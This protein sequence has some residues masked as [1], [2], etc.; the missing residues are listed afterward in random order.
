MESKLLTILFLLIFLF[1]GLVTPISAHMMGQPPSFKVN[2]V[3]T[4]N[5][6]IPA[7]SI[8]DLVLPQDIAPQN[9]LVD[10]PLNFEIDTTKLP[11]PLNIVQKL[12]FSWA[13]GD[14]ATGQGIANTHAYQK[15]GSYILT[16]NAQEPDDPTNYLIQSILINIVP[17]QNYQI[18]Q[19]VI[20]VLGKVVTNP[21]Q[22]INS[23]FSNSV[24]FD[25]SGSKSSSQ[26][27]SFKWDF[28]DGTE[29]TQPSVS[30]QYSTSKY[31]V[32]PVLRIKTADGFISDSYAQLINNG[33]NTSPRLIHGLLAIGC[34]AAALV[35]I[36]ILVKSRGRVW[37][38]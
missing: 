2:G 15:I 29:S 24:Q 13:F 11:I 28:G 32:S 25:A 9:Y 23:N 38:R 18:P 21:Q 26:I 1:Q 17:T 7:T 27:L 10:D 33:S 30:H 8:P 20:S 6:P 5:Y 16:I 36:L 4:N 3:Y 37:V 31:V 14:G 19:A 22:V 35:I 12:Q 34:I